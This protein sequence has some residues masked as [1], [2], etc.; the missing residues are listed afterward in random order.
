MIF[1]ESQA[2]RFE[3]I[4]FKILAAVEKAGSANS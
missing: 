2:V 3:L 4:D 1:L